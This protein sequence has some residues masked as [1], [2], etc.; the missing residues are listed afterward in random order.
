MA[1][2]SVFGLSLFKLLLLFI[3]LI[4]THFFYPVY[5]AEL[6]QCE[7]ESSLEP[8]T[9]VDYG[10]NYTYIPIIILYY[11]ILS[12][13]LYF[14]GIASRVIIYTLIL[15]SIFLF[16]S[17]VAVDKNKRDMFNEYKEGV[18][19][20]Y[21][22]ISEK[23]ISKIESGLDQLI[24]QEYITCHKH[25][26]VLQAAG[27]MKKLNMTVPE[28]F[29]DKIKIEQECISGREEQEIEKY[30]DDVYTA[31]ELCLNISSESK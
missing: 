23:N 18:S 15:V 1:K 28:N 4:I 10:F 27:G 13:A 29:C 6:A 26:F 20:M 5:T 14:L 7:A 21:S 30:S 11:F 2:K 12:I 9:Q 8:C 3:M 17:A 16:L 24:E 31:K 19:T 25:S 22:G